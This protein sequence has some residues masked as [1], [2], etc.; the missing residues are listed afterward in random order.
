MTLKEL[1][2]SSLY[3]DAVETVFIPYHYGQDFLFISS[4][5][6]Q[7]FWFPAYWFI[8]CQAMAQVSSVCDTDMLSPTVQSEILQSYSDV[9]I[10][11]L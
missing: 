1:I 4:R 8:P 7:K 5:L 9:W 10:I 2:G 11:F 3:E 6:I